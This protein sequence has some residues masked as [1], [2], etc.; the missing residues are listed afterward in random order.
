MTAGGAGVAVGG[1]C[2]EDGWGFFRG[3]RGCPSTGAD[4]ILASSSRPGG[5]NSLLRVM[6]ARWRKATPTQHAHG[7]HTFATRSQQ[8]MGT[9]KPVF[10]PK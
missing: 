7:Y 1:F 9:Q 8:K 6:P 3:R 10:V 2:R 4:S 5:R